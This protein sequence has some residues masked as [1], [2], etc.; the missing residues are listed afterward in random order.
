MADVTLL[1]Y[2]N[3]AEGKVDSFNVTSRAG[4]NTTKYIFFVRSVNRFRQ[5]FH[6][7][8]GQEPIIVIYLFHLFI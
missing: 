7:Y 5:F 8:I 1:F 6:I 2:F 3:A 4:L